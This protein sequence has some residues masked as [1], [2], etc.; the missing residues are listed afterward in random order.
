MLQG[1]LLFLLLGLWR[2]WQAGASAARLWATPA[3][4]SPSSATTADRPFMSRTRSQGESG[5]R[6]LRPP[7][8]ALLLL[9]LPVGSLL[10]RLKTCLL[11]QPQL[12]PDR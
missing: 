5:C 1:L 10:L 11:L 7:A 9:R 12:R 3:S 8:A 4:P 2:G 6:L